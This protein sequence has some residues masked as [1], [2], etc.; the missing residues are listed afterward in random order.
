MA[1]VEVS[2]SISSLDGYIF[3]KI[4]GQGGAGIVIKYVK[5]S[6]PYAIKFI[7]DS[8]G[9]PDIHREIRI[10][11]SLN[12]YEYP[13]P[14]LISSGY[15][16]ESIIISTLP[17]YLWSIFKSKNSCLV[18]V[19]EYIEGPNLYTYLSNN[20][21]LDNE[22]MYN[23]A[24]WLFDIIRSLHHLGIVH[25]DIKLDNIIITPEQKL[26]LVDFGLSCSLNEKINLCPT[27]PN[28][29]AYYMA[30]ELWKS[31]V[32]RDKYP[33]G[34]VWAAGVV[35]YEIL[36]NEPPWD[37]TSDEARMYRL[38]PV[39]LQKIL[40]HNIIKLPMIPS[41]YL[42]PISNAI[43]MALV[44]DV[45]QRSSADSIYQFLIMNPIQD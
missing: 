8:L 5:D 1:A 3:E 39:K 45:N 22:S 21:P 34:D 44:K 33:A 43:S 11:K 32:S 31:N 14:R 27:T 26:Y 6:V 40:R 37:V 29:T 41:K 17:E 20:Y 18:M 28:G 25:R 35:L 15:L 2:S 7:F 12:L 23:I 42:D 30:P 13:I 4:L 38:N 10:L 9:D 24:V 19:M 36:N 16:S